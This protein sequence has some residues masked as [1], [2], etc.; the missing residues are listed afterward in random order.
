MKNR[1]KLVIRITGY[2]DTVSVFVNNTEQD[3]TTL[4]IDAVYS[5]SV[6]LGECQ[7]RVIKGSG[8]LNK[9]WKKKIA[10]HW[11]SCLSGVPDF[12]LRDALLEAN[13]CSISF[14]VNINAPDQI[15]DVKLALTSA[16]FELRQGGENCRNILSDFGRD[17]TALNRIR[18]F[19][20]MPAIL[21]M[22]V[23]LVSLF[24][25]GIAALV[26][27]HIWQFAVVIGST[28]LLFTLLFYLIKKSRQ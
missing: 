4:L 21:L 23:L 9:H 17:I 2:T 19:Y 18:T 12:T 20:F 27:G 25:L 14:A 10:F 15:V 8:I 7:V 1:A 22:L 3:I 26:H 11:L 6:P 16:G 5:C 28:V 13:T 24:S